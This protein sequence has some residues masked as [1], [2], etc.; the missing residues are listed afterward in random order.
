MKIRLGAIIHTAL[1]CVAVMPVATATAQ[2]T[3]D[4][5]SSLRV[6]NATVTL[7]TSVPAGT[8]WLTAGG[9]VATDLTL[10]DLPAFCRVTATLKPSP[11]SDIN[12]EVWMPTAGW[13][14]KFQAVGNGGW[15]GTIPYATAVPRSLATALRRGY[16]TAATD[17]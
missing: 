1:V 16:A 14:G 6:P 9:P 11:D 13:N 17:T 10:N 4:A 5:L 3:C 15:G 2:T 8:L 12:I 7:S